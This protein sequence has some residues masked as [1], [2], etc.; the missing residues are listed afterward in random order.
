MNRLAALLFAVVAVPA[1]AEDWPQFRG[2]T[3]QGH[4][5]AVGLPLEW[6]ETRNVLWKTPVGG[7]GWSSPVVAGG[8]V[9]LTSVVETRGARRDLV[10]ASLRALAFDV[11][12]GREV[13]NVEV[14]RLDNPGEIN[15]KNSR[16][17]PTPIVDGDRVYVHFGA[18]GTAALTTAGKILWAT[19]LRYDSQHGSGGSPVLYR[20]V[21]IVNCDGWGDDAYVVAIDTNTGRT[22]WKTARRRPCLRCLRRRQRR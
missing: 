17:S 20:D 7:L 10:T 13:V 15:T 8:R 4:S 19:R 1:Q 22:R 6:S 2:P 5:R 11:A 9:W 14:F 3:G 12:S 21:L 16:A 18:E